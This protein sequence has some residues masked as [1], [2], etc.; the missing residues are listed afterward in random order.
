MKRG[1]N[2]KQ[3][4]ELIIER[5]NSNKDISFDIAALKVMNISRLTQVARE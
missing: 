2:Q 1:R 3:M 4:N 5:K